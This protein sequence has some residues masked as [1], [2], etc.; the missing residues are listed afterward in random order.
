METAPTK[1]EKYHP[2]SGVTENTE[3][4]VKVEIVEQ[5][6]KKPKENKKDKSL[7]DKYIVIDVKQ[8]AKKKFTT[9]ITGLQIFSKNM[10][11]FRNRQQG[12]DE[13]VKQKVR[14]LLLGPGLR[15]GS[16]SKGFL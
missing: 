16:D 12:H 10:F 1:V 6:E 4:D 2:S 7:K 8:R 9:T 5:T 13:K 3:E 15:V 11:K 14:L